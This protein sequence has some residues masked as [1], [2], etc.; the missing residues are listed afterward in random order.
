[1]VLTNAKALR[2]EFN[3]SLTL[4]PRTSPIDENILGFAKE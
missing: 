1:M 2:L 3:P 4:V